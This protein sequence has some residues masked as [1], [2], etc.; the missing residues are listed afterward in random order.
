LYDQAV[1]GFQQGQEHINVH[2][3]GID[4]TDVELCGTDLYGIVPEYITSA[5]IT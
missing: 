5:G 2:T 3:I 1:V 4:M